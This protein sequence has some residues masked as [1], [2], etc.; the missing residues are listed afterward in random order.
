MKDITLF[1]MLN[2][3][4]PIVFCKL[5]SK[6]RINVYWCEVHKVQYIMKY[7]LVIAVKLLPFN[8]FMLV[9]DT[10][11]TSEHDLNRG[12]TA[13]FCKL[14]VYFVYKMV[15]TL[16]SGVWDYRQISVILL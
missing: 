12:H 5:N 9:D 16:F 11:L 7:I 2:E 3:G 13:V 14:N 8:I 1:V 15:I 4:Y 6:E 10:N